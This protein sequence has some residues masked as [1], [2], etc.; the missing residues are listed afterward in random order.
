V[1]NLAMPTGVSNAFGWKA[2]GTPAKAHA[3]QGGH[4]AS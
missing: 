2:T 3:A 4:R 1:A